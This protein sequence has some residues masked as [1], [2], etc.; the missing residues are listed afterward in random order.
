MEETACDRSG[1]FKRQES[2]QVSQSSFPAR[3]K[4]LV[5]IAVA[6][7]SPRP[8]RGGYIVPALL[9]CPFTI[10]RVF[11]NIPNRPN[12][13]RLFLL[14]KAFHK[15]DGPFRWLIGRMHGQ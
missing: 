15:M 4:V 9:S 5:E 2:Q 11:L 14:I 1:L 13:F 3:A 10:Q 7:N 12:Q 6:W 8:E